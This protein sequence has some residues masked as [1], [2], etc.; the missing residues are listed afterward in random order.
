MKMAG[1]QLGR[2]VK[3]NLKLDRKQINIF[4]KCPPSPL[5]RILPFLAHGPSLR[6]PPNGVLLRWEGP[7][8]LNPPLT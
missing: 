4:N 5:V 2:T 8:F 1:S 7:D 3:R 6:I